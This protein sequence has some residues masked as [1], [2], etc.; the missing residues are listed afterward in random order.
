MRQII[1]IIAILSS[2]ALRPQ[3]TW[4]PLHINGRSMEREWRPNIEFAG[5]K[6]DARCI[7]QPRHQGCSQSSFPFP[8]LLFLPS[9]LRWGSFFLLTSS[10]SLSCFFLWCRLSGHSHYRCE[11]RK[12]CQNRGCAPGHGWTCVQ[13]VK[14]LFASDRGA[15]TVRP[16]GLPSVGQR[17]GS[18]TSAGAFEFCR[19]DHEQIDRAAPAV[20]LAFCPV[21]FMRH[22]ARYNMR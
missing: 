6:S 9:L 4:Y 1:I 3:L 8:L 13:R 21:N 17:W 5:E 19:K 12:Q 10:R 20:R 11:Q 2:K 16:I 14:L 15:T 22:L 7:P 18:Q